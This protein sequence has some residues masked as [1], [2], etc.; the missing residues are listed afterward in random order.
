MD[1]YSREKFRNDGMPKR[2]SPTAGLLQEVGDLGGVDNLKKNYVT[3]GA[4]IVA[5]K[6]NVQLETL[7]NEVTDLRRDLDLKPNIKLVKKSSR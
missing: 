5:S 3:E 1:R 2:L 7:T 4:L 6:V